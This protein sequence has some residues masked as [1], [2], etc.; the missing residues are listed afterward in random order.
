[1]TKPAGLQEV[2]FYPAEGPDAYPYV[3]FLWAEPLGE[4][5]FRIRTTPFTVD[6]IALGDVV[7]TE[8]DPE[9]HFVA[10]R[11][12]SG[13]SALRIH[14]EPEVTAEMFFSALGAL[15]CAHA[16]TREPRYFA[17]DVPASVAITDVLDHLSDGQDAGRCDWDA[18][19]I[20][21]VHGAQLRAVMDPETLPDWVPRD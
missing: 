14:V 21:R 4:G 16:R 20:S 7:E 12:Q 1:V 10:L 9:L 2:A 11:E 6:G 8:E 15:G 3:E 5:L 13:H 17:L 18:G 19:S